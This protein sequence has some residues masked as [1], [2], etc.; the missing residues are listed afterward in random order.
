MKTTPAD[1]SMIERIFGLFD[2]SETQ[3]IQTIKL[4]GHFYATTELPKLIEYDPVSLATIGTVDLSE[5]LPYRVTTMTPHPQYDNDGTLWNVGIAVTLTLKVKYVVFKVT[6]PESP[7]QRQNPWLNTQV[8]A[9]IPSPKPGAI[10]YFHSFFMTSNYLV[11]PASPWTTGNLV[12][13]ITEYVFQGKSF[14]DATM[15]WDDSSMLE[16]IVVDKKQEKTLPI[17]YV[18]DPGKVLKNMFKDVFKFKKKFAL[19]L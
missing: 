18:A 14:M 19:Q 2:M 8:V 3:N 10:P 12:K 15:Y 7:E 4:F 9:E 5:L 17:R 11:I 13:I 1:W 6:P 16:F